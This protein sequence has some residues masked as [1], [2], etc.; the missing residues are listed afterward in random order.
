MD[1]QYL[2]E[3]TTTISAIQRAAKLSKIVLAAANNRVG[4]IDKDDH[5]P[6]TVADFACQAI[7]TA[8]LT[9]A[10][11]NDSFVGEEAA[12]DL[13]ANPDLLAAVWAILQEVKAAEV[14][15]EDGASVVHFPTSPDHAC[16]LIDRAGLGQPHQ[17][18]VWVFDPIDGTKTY[19]R[20]EI[21]AVNAC[22][23]VDGKQTVAVVGLP[24]LSPDA[25]PPIQNHTIDRNPHGGSLL[26]AVRGRGSF[27]RPLPG[28]ADLAG[29]RIPQH[30]TDTSS[31]RLVTSTDAD[32]SIPGIHE[33]I[34][35]RMGLAY[36]GNDLLG[37][38]PRWASLALGHANVTFWVYKKRERL[39]KIWD[40]AGAMLMFQEAGG[41]VT[42]VDGR[43]PDLTAG[44]KMVAN[45]GWVAAPAGVHAEILAAVQDAVRAEGHG[46]LLRPLE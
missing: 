44:R 11:P 39:G 46:D 34:A 29:T 40:H 14:E 33:K 9:A 10:F 32:S 5:S 41:K 35:T 27:L 36:P 45:F 21:Y 1:S 8:T 26:Y 4:H 28:A 7:L 17:G 15:G 23:L 24:N 6:V 20:G 30:P 31:Y 43:E 12:D 19:L 13:R 3:L 42:D 16:E 38:V 2:A 22:L 18:R 25:T 37:W